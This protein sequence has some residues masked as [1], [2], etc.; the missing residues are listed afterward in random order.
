MALHAAIDRIIEGIDLIV[1]IAIHGI[2]NGDGLRVSGTI[3]REGLCVR[4]VL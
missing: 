2:G 3:G 1:V 4:R